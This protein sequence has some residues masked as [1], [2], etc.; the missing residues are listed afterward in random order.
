MFMY[1]INTNSNSWVFS[2]PT[3]TKHIDEDLDV[4]DSGLHHEC[5]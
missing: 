1:I 5:I 2:P 3:K 4:F